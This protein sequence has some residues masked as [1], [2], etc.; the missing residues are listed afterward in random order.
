MAGVPFNI[1]LSISPLCGVNGINKCQKYLLEEIKQIIDNK[2][3]GH[4]IAY[5]DEDV[6]G[7]IVN[8][9]ITIKQKDIFVTIPINYIDVFINGL[10]QYYNLLDKYPKF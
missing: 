4:L 1:T 6:F 8:D 7:I 2:K 10:Q 5:S 9:I 3:G